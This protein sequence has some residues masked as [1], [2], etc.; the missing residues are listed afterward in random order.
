MAHIAGEEC[1]AEGSFPQ[2][3]LIGCLGSVYLKKAATGEIQSIAHAGGP[4][5]GGDGEVV[6]R[7]AMSPVMNNR[8]DIVFLGD[9]TPPPAA[10]RPPQ[11]RS[12]SALG[13]ADHGRGTP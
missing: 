10:R 8:G 7:Q 5:P 9:L 4:A 3:I 12:V 11:G 1:R 2:A 13:R 6:Y